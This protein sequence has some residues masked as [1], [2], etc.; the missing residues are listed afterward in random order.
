MHLHKSVRRRGV[1]RRGMD[2]KIK[3]FVNRIKCLCK[4]A[5]H[6]TTLHYTT[7]HY[8][9]LHYTFLTSSCCI[10]RAR[11]NPSPCPALSLSLSLSRSRSSPS[12]TNNPSVYVLLIITSSR[13]SAIS[14]C[15]AVCAASEE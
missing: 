10:A 14:T 3:F 6:C 1:R 7:L 2:E 11:L 13:S 4:E 9:A 12:C 15:A 5:Q 8:T